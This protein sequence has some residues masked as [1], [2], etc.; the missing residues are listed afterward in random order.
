MERG[1]GASKSYSRPHFLLKKARATYLL[2]RREVGHAYPI[3][4][5]GPLVPKKCHGKW[6]RIVDARDV[7]RLENLDNLLSDMFYKIADGKACAYDREAATYLR[8]V[9]DHFLHALHAPHSQ[10]PVTIEKAMPL[11]VITHEAILN[12]FR[13]ME[14]GKPFNRDVQWLSGTTYREETEDELDGGRSDEDNSDSD[15]DHAPKNM[16]QGSGNAYDKG[17]S[18]R[19]R[20]L[21]PR[22]TESPVRGRL[23]PSKAGPVP[24]LVRAPRSK[25]NPRLQTAADEVETHPGAQDVDS[26]IEVV[27]VKTAKAEKGAPPG[28]K[29]TSDKPIRTF[30]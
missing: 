5:S 2:A 6:Y 26:D 24:P 10:P 3:D 14:D 29:P 16:K 23:Q 13:N 1:P 20:N 27:W 18:K 8:Q 7:E 30:R 9:L 19:R 25:K 4:R 21:Q 28:G 15:R 12:A 22:E 17:S 11:K